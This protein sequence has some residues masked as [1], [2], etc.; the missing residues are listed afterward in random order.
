MVQAEG[1]P[2][3]AAPADSNNRSRLQENWGS[4]CVK[5]HNT[6]RHANDTHARAQTQWNHQTQCLNKEGCGHNRWNGGYPSSRE[7]VRAMS[8]PPHW[9]P[10]GPGRWRRWTRGRGRPQLSS[11]S[12]SCGR[13]AGWKPAAGGA[14]F[15]SGPIFFGTRAGLHARDNVP[16]AS[17]SDLGGGSPQRC[18]YTSVAHNTRAL[19]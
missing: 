4:G 1:R 15:H 10:R 19:V 11:T 14:P 9:F 2:E 12:C 6:R 3:G 16:Q 17:F 7:R 8:H 18:N 5:I 13:A